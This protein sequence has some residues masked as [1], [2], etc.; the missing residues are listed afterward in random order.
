MS[1]KL[2]SLLLSLLIC[3][4]TFAST[5]QSLFT[6]PQEIVHSGKVYRLA[7]KKELANGRAIYEYTT[8]AETIEKWTTLV[9]LN[10]A[11][12]ISGTQLEWAT[13]L[14]K[15]LDAD[16]PRPHYLIYNKNGFDYARIIYEPNAL[17][18]TYE[19]NAH[20]KFDIADCG[21]RIIYQFAAIYPASV[22]QSDEGKMKTLMSIYNENQ[23][24]SEA[25]E[26]NDWLPS[27]KSAG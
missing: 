5:E 17:N 25:L 18:P 16:K 7:F 15:A 26:K 23:V 27:C 6:G 13:T 19:S 24:F 4:V 11:K 21:G 1:L 10:Y 12:G 20:K 8:D 2:T 22:D 14:K 9:T 3:S